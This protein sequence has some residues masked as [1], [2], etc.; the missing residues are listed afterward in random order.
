MSLV[1][2]LRDELTQQLAQGVPF[3]HVVDK[4]AFAV[5]Q[6]RG[7][8]LTH[9]ELMAAAIRVDDLRR[10]LNYRRLR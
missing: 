10:P 7:A 1:D 9:T 8:E 2:W 5:A 3:S 4:A 6:T